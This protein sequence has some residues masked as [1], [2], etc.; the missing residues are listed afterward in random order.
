MHSTRTLIAAILMTVAVT[1]ALHP[2][3]LSAGVAP[4]ERIERSIDKVTSELHDLTR[5]VQSSRR[6]VECR[7]K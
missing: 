3:T 2:A 1:F 5:A 4:D 6:S 7:C